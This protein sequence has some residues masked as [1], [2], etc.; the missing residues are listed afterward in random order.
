M[1]YVAEAKLPPRVFGATSGDGGFVFY[2]VR[3]IINENVNRIR[4]GCLVAVFEIVFLST[5]FYALLTVYGNASSIVNFIPGSPFIIGAGGIG[6]MLNYY[7]A[8]FSKRVDFN[9]DI[10]FR[11]SSDFYTVIFRHFW[12]ASG[13]YSEQFHDLVSGRVYVSSTQ[14]RGLVRIPRARIAA[15]VGI[16]EAIVE[17]RKLSFSPLFARLLGTDLVRLSFKN[18]R[19]AR[20]F[21]NLLSENSK[22][23]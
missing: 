18:E 17:L 7:V 4:R 6:F 9:S 3:Q 19:E 13:Y 1:R 11:D 2:G 8:P 20:T 16:G 15:V 5:S 23:L 21:C 22:K 14:I 10:G 12:A